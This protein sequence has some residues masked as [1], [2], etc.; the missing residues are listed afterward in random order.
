M[1]SSRGRKPPFVLATALCLVP[2]LA[3]AATAPPQPKTG[4]GGSEATHA[5][6]VSATFGSGAKAY[7]IFEPADPAPEQAPVVVFLHGWSAMD[8]RAYGSWI[9]HLVRRGNI[10]IYPRYQDSLRTPVRDFTPNALAAV[11]DAL[12]RLGSEPSHVRPDLGKFALAGHSMGGVLAANLAALASSSGLP[13][14]RAVLAAEPGKTWAESGSIAVHLEDLGRIPK[15]TLLV[16]IAGDADTLA[17]DIDAKKI[18]HGATSIP[19]ENRNM[20]RMRSDDHGSP[21]LDATHYAPV[22]PGADFAEGATSPVAAAPAGGA[23]ANSAA[24]QA[25]TFRE[26]MRER[27]RQRLSARREASGSSE[28][29]SAA[30]MRGV[31]ALDFYGTWKLLDALTDAAFFGKNREYALGNTPQ[32]RFMGTWSDGVAVKE[33]EVTT[34]P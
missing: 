33:L 22:A 10:V 34:G 9:D 23:A 12:A 6:V 4:P 20:V 30:P 32:Q 19:P 21:P 29:Q 15:D 13:A 14:P 31:D 5:K 26:R 24:P 28:G 18:F 3:V 2:I 11:K 7:S 1:T 8:P 25:G 17:R 16:T 27:I